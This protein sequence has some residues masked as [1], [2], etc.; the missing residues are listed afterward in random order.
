MKSLQMPSVNQR[1]SLYQLT[2]SSSLEYAS[3]VWDPNQRIY[4]VRIEVIQM[5]AAYWVSN[6]YS[7]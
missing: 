5:R 3:S 6:N 7:R 1:S 4:I 2:I